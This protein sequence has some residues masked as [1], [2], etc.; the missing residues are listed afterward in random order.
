MF[1]LLS[2]VRMLG[3]QP[4]DSVSVSVFF[5]CIKQFVED[6]KLPLFSCNGQFID[7]WPF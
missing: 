1:L 6:I 4:K 3:R 2:I 7:Y 5:N